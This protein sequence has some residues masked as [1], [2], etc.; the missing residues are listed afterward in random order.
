MKIN[1]LS[2]KPK[3]FQLLLKRRKKGFQKSSVFSAH[4]RYM[5]P[6]FLC[7]K[8]ILCDI[9]LRRRLC[10]PLGEEMGNL[11]ILNP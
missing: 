10:P 11:K 4:S 5:P 3:R 8:A 7:L 9:Y 2:V 1:M 6:E